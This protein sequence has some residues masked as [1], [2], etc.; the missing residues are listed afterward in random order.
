MT[1]HPTLP[2]ALHPPREGCLALQ[3]RGQ[4]SNP[5]THREKTKLQQERMWLDTRKNFP[6]IREVYIPQGAFWGIL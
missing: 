5:K 6:L 1:G 3:K 4:E 2:C